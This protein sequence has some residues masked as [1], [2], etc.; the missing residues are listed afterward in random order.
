M[1]LWRSLIHGWRIGWRRRNFSARRHGWD[2]PTSFCL[3]EDVEVLMVKCY[4]ALSHYCP[5]VMSHLRSRYLHRDIHQPIC[6]LA[7]RPF[8]YNLL[9]L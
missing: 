8:Q 9:G 6:L 1:K 7:Q 4:T 5:C 3:S 2:V